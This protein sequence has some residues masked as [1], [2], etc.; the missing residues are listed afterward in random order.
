M[1]HDGSV[2]P[3]LPRM[4]WA[5]YG[6][7]RDGCST[8]VKL[9]LSLH[10]EADAPA[11]ASV[12]EARVCERAELRKILVPLPARLGTDALALHGHGRRGRCREDPR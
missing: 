8:G 7:G 5:R 4:A 6:A 1:S 12:C 3:A 2:F 10:V 11:K 9:H